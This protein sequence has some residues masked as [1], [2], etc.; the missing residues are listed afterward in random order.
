MTNRIYNVLIFDIYNLF[1]RAFWKHDSLTKVDGKLIPVDG[2]CNFF[3]ILNSYIEKY[4]TKNCRCYFL[5]DNAK[6]MI[7]RRKEID[8]N[9]KKDRKEMPQEFYDALNLIELILKFYRDNSCT[10][11]KEGLEADDYVTNLINLYIQPN[12][13]VLLFSTDIDWC[14]CLLDKDNVVVNQYTRNNEVLTTKTFEEKYGFKPTVTNITF[15][16]TFY[17]D[18]SDNIPSTL[19]NYPKSYFL[20]CLKRYNHVDN[21]IQDVEDDKLIYLDTAWRIRIKQLQERMRLNWNLISAIEINITDL[22]SWKVECTY[23]PNKLLIIYN[24]LN[25]LVKFDNRIKIENKKDSIWNML[26]GESLERV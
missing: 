2:I 24:T 10:Y 26:E 19:S 5:F 4:G 16:K 22:E 1:H 18:I 7:L 3:S 21:F 23:K 8:E 25:V 9:Y 20:D 15:W 13:K 17:G 11:R 14:R 12:D 6:S